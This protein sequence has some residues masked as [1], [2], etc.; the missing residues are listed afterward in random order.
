V[1]MAPAAAA[2]TR[3][4]ATTATATTDLLTHPF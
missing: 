1:T 4:T 2:I 3:N